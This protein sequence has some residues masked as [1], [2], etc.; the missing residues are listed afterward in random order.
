MLIVKAIAG[1]AA[2]EWPCRI[3]FWR[4]VFWF[5]S[6]WDVSLV[7]MS[8]SCSGFLLLL[9]RLAHR[10]VESRCEADDSPSGKNWSASIIIEQFENED[11]LKYPRSAVQSCTHMRTS[12][13]ARTRIQ[14]RHS[15]LIFRSY[16][17]H[18]PRSF[19]GRL[20]ICG[21]H[22]STNSD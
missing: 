18:R 20:R 22:A 10:Q 16:Y 8:A 13:H 14:Y 7:F 11:Y 15:L 9:L 3:T 19:S 6:T 21:V 1:A 12:M 17:M 2:N 4:S 5:C